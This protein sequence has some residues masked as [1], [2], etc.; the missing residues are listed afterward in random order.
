LEKVPGDFAIDHI[1]FA[2]TEQQRDELITVL[3]DFG[4]AA[5]D[6]HLNFP[7]DGVA[8]D[9]VGFRG[10]SFLEFVYRTAPH[11]GP[12]IWFAER[13]RVIGLGFSASD[14]AADTDWNSEPGAWAM[15]EQQGFPNSAGPHEHHSD[16]Y[17]FVMN[18]KDGV[19][20]FPELTAGPKL[21]EITLTWL[22]I[23]WTMSCW[24][25]LARLSRWH[26]T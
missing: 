12:A 8:S 14:F 10:G 22:P 26:C 1:V 17:I 3:R 13:P 2:A 7:D 21:A 24:A 25:C 15:P 19:L 23:S 4:F 9:S 20:Q 5:V 6:F 11:G 16:F 18:R